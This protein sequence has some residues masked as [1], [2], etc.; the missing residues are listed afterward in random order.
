MLKLYEFKLQLEQKSQRDWKSTIALEVAEAEVD[1]KLRYQGQQGKS[2]LGLIPMNRPA[3]DTKEYRHLVTQAIC[4]QEE[5]EQLVKVMDFAMQGAWTKWD[6]V[7]SLDLSWNNLIYSLPPKL[8]SFALNAT[9]LTLPTPDRLRVW[10]YTSLSMCKLCSHPKSSLFHILCNCPFSLYNKRY[11]WRHDSVLRTIA[12]VV[13]ARI[14]DQN[15]KQPRPRMIREIKF[16]RAGSKP[17][18]AHRK[19]AGSG[20]LS[21]ANDWK[22]LVDYT[23]TPIIFPPSI[24]ATDQRPDIVIWSE[25]TKT[26]ILIELTIPYEDNIVDA[27]FRKKN[28]YSGLIDACRSATWDAHLWTVEV[29]VRGFVAGSLR[30]C[31]KSLD[32]LNPTISRTISAASK[33][34]LRCSYSIYLARNLPA[35]KPLELLTDGLTAKTAHVGQRDGT[36]GAI[37]C[38]PGLT[39]DVTWIGESKWLVPVS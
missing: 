30:K 5:H 13:F 35:W 7:M 14:K 2:C 36:S 24:T 17:P 37:D 8:L 3:S 4:A 28:K 39:C 16:V 10:N 26:V 9:Q 38:G 27:E 32:V 1:F 15:S 23:G 22:C 25:M 19:D 21:Y 33:T 11:E 29:G 20:L 12:Q 31:L 34:A 6:S 18:A